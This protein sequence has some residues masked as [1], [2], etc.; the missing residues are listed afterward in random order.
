MSSEKKIIIEVCAGS[1]EDCLAA[2]K[3]GASRVELNSALSVGGLSPSVATLRNVKNDTDL[4]V[5]CMVR[6]RAGGFCYSDLEARIMLD[7]AK[8]LLEAGADGIAF[9][10]LNPDGTV[11]LELTKAMADLIHSY[12]EREAVFHRAIDVTPDLLV[13]L[14]QLKELGIDRVLTSGNQAKALQGCDLIRQMNEAADGKIEILPGSGVNASN[15]KTILEQILT[16]GNQAKALQG[17]DLI[18]QMNEAADGKIEILPGS[19]VNAS[20][21]KTIL[22]Q[23]GVH[24]LHSSC[25][26]YKTDPTTKRGGVSYAY[27]DGEHEMDYDVV[28]EEL[29][30]KLVETVR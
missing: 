3:G 17:C 7:E 20:N 22:E 6:P 16:S 10:F 18:R 13:A 1:Y 29:V 2:Q 27:L 26:A 11:H 9:G 4:K 25:K 12:P 28:S 8:D 5:I 24:Q 19:G 15:A 21:A 14:E 23:T 30:T